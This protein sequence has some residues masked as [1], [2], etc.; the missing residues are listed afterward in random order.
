MLNIDSVSYSYGD[1]EILNNVNVKVESGEIVGLVGTNGAGKSTLIHNIIGTLEPDHG[2]ITINGL[3]P[4]ESSD[5]FGYV[6]EENISHKSLNVKHFLLFSARLYGVDKSVAQQRYRSILERMNFDETAYNT[7][8]H[9]LSNGMKRKV[10][11]ARSIIHDPDVFIYDEPTGGLDYQT[12]QTVLAELQN[13]A[14][15]GKTIIFTSHNLENVQQLCDRVLFLHNGGVKTETQLNSKKHTYY[16]IT[17]SS[18]NNESIIGGENIT[19]LNE[20]KYRV[21]GRKTFNLLMERFPYDENG[22]VSVSNETNHIE[23][24]FS[25][26]K[27]GGET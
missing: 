22:I 21:D 20:T 17:D 1:V 23:D 15:D 12:T 5:L 25:A 8:L 9:N 16:V 2:D 3:S 7:Q 11:I 26:Y 27:S 10:L 4:K 19:R 24:L 18:L 13:M 14:S 6:P